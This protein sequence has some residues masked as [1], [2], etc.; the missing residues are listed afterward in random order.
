M[1]RKKEAMLKEERERE[2]EWV[3]MTGGD[4]EKKKRDEA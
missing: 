4:G 3:G 1:N 2:E